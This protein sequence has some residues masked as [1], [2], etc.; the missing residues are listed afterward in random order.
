MF[1]DLLFDAHGGGEK[2]NK[3]VASKQLKE[4]ASKELLPNNFNSYSLKYVEEVID[5]FLDVKE[6]SLVR[7]VGFEGTEEYQARM[8]A[9]QKTGRDKVKALMSEQEVRNLKD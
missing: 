8:K 4:R 9:I 2:L 3:L 7:G 6:D 1:V 5:V